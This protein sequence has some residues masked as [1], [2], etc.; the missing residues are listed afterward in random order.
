ML[1]TDT[2][3]GAV[4]GLPLGAA[5]QMEVANKKT[6]CN[7]DFLLVSPRVKSHIKQHC[8]NKDFNKAMLM[9]CLSFSPCLPPLPI[10][11]ICWIERLNRFATGVSRLFLHWCLPMAFIP[12]MYLFSRMGSNAQ[13]GCESFAGKAGCVQEECTKVMLTKHSQA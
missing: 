3:V 4:R 2:P 10:S 12:G 5:A 13:L 6:E 7:H 9:D 8:V 11:Y 1:E